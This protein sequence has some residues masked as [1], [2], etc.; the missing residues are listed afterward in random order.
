MGLKNKT[1]LVTGGAGFIGSHLVDNLLEKDIK[2][3][4]IYDDFSTGR[5]RN[6]EYLKGNGKVRIIRGNILDYETLRQAVRDTEVIFLIASST[7]N[8]MKWDMS[9]LFIVLEAIRNWS[10]P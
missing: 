2:N 8:Y 3:V 6:V 9:S 10:L 1:V 5:E 7:I 4:I